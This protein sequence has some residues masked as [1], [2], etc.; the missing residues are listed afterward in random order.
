VRPIDGGDPAK[1][2]K[3]GD[4]AVPDMIDGQ[5][6]TGGLVTADGDCF[7]PSDINPNYN[8]PTAFQQPR[9]IR[10]DARVTF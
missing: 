10:I 7:Q 6:S 8:N 2:P 9:Q 3:K 1:L 5:C 4:P